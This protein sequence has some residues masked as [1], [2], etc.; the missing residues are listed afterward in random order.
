M[1]KPAIVAVGY[2]RPEA[3]KRLL[4]S[5]SNAY[6]EMDD[7]TL[8]VSIDECD[9]SN[10]VENAARSVEWKHGER[11]IR[12]FSERQGLRRHI[13]QCG[14]LSQKYG[15]VIIL[16]DDLVVAPSFYQYTFEAINFYR[17]EP[18]I[19]GISLYS[20]GWNGYAGLEFVPAK[21][22]YD[23]Y[24]GQYSISWGQ[25]WSHVH[26]KGFKGWYEKNEGKLPS[27]N[28]RMPAS[29]LTWSDHSWGKYFAS[30]IAENELYYVVPYTSL[31]TNFSEIGQ[32]CS[33]ADS[34]H[35]V[36]LMTGIKKNYSFP[37]IDDA[38]KYDMFFERELSGIS[39]SGI[40]GSEICV[41][42]NISKHSTLDKRYLLSPEKYDFKKISSFS[43]VM[44][45]IDANVIC[46]IPG[47]DI[48]LYDCEKT[49]VSL[50]ENRFN[51]KRLN[52]DM[53]GYWWNM[54]L[55]EGCRRFT[56]ALKQKFSRMKR[57]RKK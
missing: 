16:E 53:Y 26:W 44:H 9:K 1:I 6:Y 12:R 20:H 52:Y 41:D 8:I 17:D 39:V 2:N 15:A 45:P 38:I 54:L 5:I 32:H 18:R 37:Q 48:F 10:E 28:L 57:K 33:Q 51:W 11:I 50:K 31:T 55:R 27:R 19:T 40:D 3:M 24:L 34:S 46:H 7:I 14:D 43:M 22:Q 29:I 13:I 25:C 21:N 49:D 47:D 4:T 35:Q 36:S 30:Y 42:L 56:V 23:T